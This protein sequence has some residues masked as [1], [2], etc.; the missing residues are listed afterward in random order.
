MFNPFGGTPGRDGNGIVS[1]VFVSST[2]GD[3]PGIEGATDTY[4]INY[5]DAPSTTYTV[6]NGSKGSQGPVGQTGAQGV[7][8]PTG[9]AGPEGPAGADGNG[10]VSITG[11]VT[12]G[13]VDTY[14]IT[15]TNGDTSTFTVTNGE[16]GTNGTDGQDGA[17][18]KDGTDGAPGA[19]GASAYDIWIDAGNAGTEAEFLASLIGAAGQNGTNGSD[20]RGIVS[21]TKTDT[22]DNVDT[23]TITYTSGSSSTFTVTNGINGTNGQD[24]AT[25][26]AGRGITSVTKTDTS[27]LVD[28]YTITYSNNTTSTFTVTNGADGQTGPAGADGNDGDDGISIT[29]TTIDANK[30]LIVS[31]SDDVDVDAGDVTIRSEQ[32]SFV[33][34]AA[35][36]AQQQDGSYNYTY[37]NAAINLTNFIDV[38]PAAGITENQLNSLLSAKMIIQAINNGS[39]VFKAYGEQPSVDI[40]MLLVVEGSYTS[41]TPVITVDDTLSLASENPV[42]NKVLTAAL[43]DKADAK[44][45][46]NLLSLGKVTLHNGYNG[47]LRSDGSVIVSTNGNQHENTGTF[48]I[49]VT[50]VLPAGT[51]KFSG[52]SGGASGTYYMCLYEKNDRLLA[53]SLDSAET[54]T[55]NSPTEVMVAIVATS[56]L[57]LTDQLFYPMVSEASIENPTFSRATVDDGFQRICGHNRIDVV[58]GD[59][60]YYLIRY[61]VISRNTPGAVIKTGYYWIESSS[62]TNNST[63]ITDTTIGPEGSPSFSL[64]YDSEGKKC[65]KVID[66][67]DINSNRD[68]M[69]E[70][71]GY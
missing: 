52:C 6:T 57:S 29:D 34:S 46:D 12:V 5:T 4:Q 35:N 8:G 22:I 70:I 45:S 36:W 61:T 59:K 68:I 40:P 51:Y 37:S 2:G 69:L 50:N 71:M 11:P 27:G 47:A 1:I 60:D 14:T 42:Q 48:D 39:I 9:P 41:V 38:G 66:N 21:I 49:V 54:F 55:V 26:P 28:T 33:L 17:P 56:G 53:C 3:T 7:P 58:I 67:N 65:I 20:G 24:G 15:F 19:P 16:D 10:I 62:G 64:Y 63:S 18:G 25:G 44:I 43:N 31:F 32:Y 13:L 23:Y 30:H